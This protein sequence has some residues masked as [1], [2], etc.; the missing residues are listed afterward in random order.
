[1][2]AERVVVAFG[3]SSDEQQCTDCGRDVQRVSF[4]SG[5]ASGA[6]RRRRLK[7]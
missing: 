1:L 7:K 3:R 6:D 5:L 4:A 2:R